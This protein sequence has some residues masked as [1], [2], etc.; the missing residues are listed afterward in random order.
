MPLIYFKAAFKVHYSNASKQY[1]DH[2][3]PHTPLDIPNQCSFPDAH[4]VHGIQQL[5]LDI[6]QQLKYSVIKILLEG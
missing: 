6:V 1:R 4:N 3:V 2:V 5:Q